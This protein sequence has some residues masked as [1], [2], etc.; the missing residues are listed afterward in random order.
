MLGYRTTLGWRQSD[1]IE[2][3]GHLSE[4]VIGIDNKPFEKANVGHL[5]GE[6]RDQGDVIY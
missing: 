2:E 1:L 5:P 6:M 4:M 3:K